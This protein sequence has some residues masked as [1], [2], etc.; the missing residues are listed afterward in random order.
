MQPGKPLNQ[1]AQEGHRKA[2]MRE[3]PM[4]MIVV[5]AEGL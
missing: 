1:R 2:L 3:V 5:V 4:E